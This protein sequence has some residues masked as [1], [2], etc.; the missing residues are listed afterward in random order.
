MRLGIAVVAMLIAAATS[1]I[2]I[3]SVLA[4]GE[5]VVEV[6]VGQDDPALE[7]D[8]EV[9]G[10]SPSTDHITL[11]PRAVGFHG[12]FTVAVA[13]AAA[14]VTLTTQLPADEELVSVGCLDD[15]TPP[16]EIT[17]SFG[18]SSFT[19]DVVSGRRYRCFAM[20]LPGDLVDPGGPPAAMTQG[21]T[22]HPLPRSDSSLTPPSPPSPGWPTVLIT[23]VVICGIA[24]LLRPVRR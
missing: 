11:A 4:Q 17:P 2:A 12:E 18:G 23:I 22:D 24:I 16:T 5:A 21:P 8:I 20:S 9:A 3:A 6:V 14:T 7:W 13:G 1:Q 10:G 19:L 15:L